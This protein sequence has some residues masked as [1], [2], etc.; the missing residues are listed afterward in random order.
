[1]VFHRREKAFNSAVV[2]VG[3]Y[4]IQRGQAGPSPH[5]AAPR[6][7]CP[8]RPSRF[9][10][11]PSPLHELSKPHLQLK[12]VRV[13]LRESVEA[14]DSVV[15]REPEGP[16]HRPL[17]AHDGLIWGRLGLQE[18]APERLLCLCP[19][20][21]GGGGDWRVSRGDILHLRKR[22]ITMYPAADGL[23]KGL[24]ACRGGVLYMNSKVEY[25]VGPEAC[26]TPRKIP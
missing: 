10:S 25:L 23:L 26:R 3:T 15:W 19:G 14:G 9:V 7:R 4:S 24:S 16:Q 13:V 5:D 12:V 18:L 20:G 17:H 11:L 22:A 21:G 1:M 2:C 6:E 8:E